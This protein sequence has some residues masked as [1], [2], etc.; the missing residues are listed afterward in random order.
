LGE[1]LVHLELPRVGFSS[2]PRAE[3]S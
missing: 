2:R 3:R 1:V